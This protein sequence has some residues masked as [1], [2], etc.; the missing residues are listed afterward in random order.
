MKLSDIKNK[1]SFLTY[2]AEFIIKK[3]DFEAVYEIVMVQKETNYVKSAIKEGS[4]SKIAFGLLRLSKYKGGI[5][6]IKE[7]YEDVR[8]ETIKKRFTKYVG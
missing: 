3:A 5:K 8:D 7:I 6:R 1:K 4:N 2:L